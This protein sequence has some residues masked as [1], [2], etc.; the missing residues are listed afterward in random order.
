MTDFLASGMLGIKVSAMS[1]AGFYA[2]VHQLKKK[3]YLRMES[4]LFT[5][6]IWDVNRI[7]HPR[8]L[9]LATGRTTGCTL[10][11]NSQRAPGK[12]ASIFIEIAAWKVTLSCN[13]SEESSIA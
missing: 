2:D 12:V 13:V 10:K 11:E 5:E 3:D 7:S 8:D 1:V 4:R 9:V 6:S